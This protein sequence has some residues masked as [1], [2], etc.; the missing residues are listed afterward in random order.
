MWQTIIFKTFDEM[1]KWQKENYN[2]YAFYQVFYNN[3]P[4]A[5]EYKP[6]KKI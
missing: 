4:Y 5:L 1:L 6:L 3:I 2:K